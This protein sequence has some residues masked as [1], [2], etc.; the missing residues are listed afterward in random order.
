MSALTAAATDRLSFPNTLPQLVQAQLAISLPA[1]LAAASGSLSHAGRRDLSLVLKTALTEALGGP[2]VR[3]WRLM[4]TRDQTAT[5]LGYTDGQDA[6]ALRGRLAF[7]T[8][9]WQQAVQ[10]VATAPLPNLTAG[11]RLRFSLRL[12]PTVNQTQGGEIDAF[13]YAV[14]Q[15]PAE[16]HNRAAVYLAYVAAR[17]H[18]AAI[19]MV[20]LHGMRLTPMVRRQGKQDWTTRTFPVADLAGDLT[21][22][23]PH[24][25]TWTLAR[26]LGRQRGYGFGAIRL[27]AR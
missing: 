9:A 23:D 5:L 12:V 21:V 22:T 4:G 13:L 27:E 7:A 26:G 2:L 20:G 1:A 17:L 3:P 10:V 15:A 8:P 25:F 24:R 6:T 11:Q 19:G 18:G 14:R 16:P